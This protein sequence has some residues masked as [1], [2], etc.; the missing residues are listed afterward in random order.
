MAEYL[1]KNTLNPYKVVKCDITFRQLVNKGRGCDPVWLVQLSTSEPHKDGG[2]INPE[3]INVS[4]LKNLDSEIKDA[5]EAIASQVDWG[6]LQSDVTPPFVNQ[7]SPLQ[8]DKNA[9]IFSDVVVSLKD[10]FP[11]TGIDPGSVRMYVN[12]FDV[13]DEIELIGDP[14]EY[15]VVWRP[16]ARVKDYY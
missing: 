5:T 9:S 13:T 3:F 10:G 8:N 14:F 12:G 11:S 16:Q 6:D 4:S 1:I 15:K 2:T 7:Y